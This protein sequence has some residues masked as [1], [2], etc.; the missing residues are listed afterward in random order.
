M[1]TID[2]QAAFYTCLED[3]IR[4]RQELHSLRED[5]QDSCDELATLR[6]EFEMRE[7]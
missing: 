3:L 2:Y 6:A 1:S 5:Y 4:T 7:V